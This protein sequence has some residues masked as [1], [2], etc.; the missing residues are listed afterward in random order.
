MKRCA[1]YS[2]HARTALITPGGVGI[3]GSLTH[4]LCLS[5]GTW[6]RTT[7]YEVG[8]DSETNQENTMAKVIVHAVRDAHNGVFITDMYSITV[9]AWDEERKEWV[10]VYTRSCPSTFSL[11]VEGEVRKD[12]LP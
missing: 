3:L 4:A 2:I 12:E 8:S 11:V 1:G 10:G 6:N 5:L 7:G 9:S